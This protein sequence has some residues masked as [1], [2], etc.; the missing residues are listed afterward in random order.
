MHCFLTCT[1]TGELE[2]VTCMLPRYI[3]NTG[4]LVSALHEPPSGCSCEPTGAFT[5]AF[6]ER[7][8]SFPMERRAY[9]SG[10]AQ[11]WR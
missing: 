1:G 7:W 3:P 5:R 11:D 4:E 2:R 8:D 6:S 10:S 9:C